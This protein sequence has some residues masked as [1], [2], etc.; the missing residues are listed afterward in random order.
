MKLPIVEKKLAYLFD[1]LVL[2]CWD[3]NGLDGGELQDA[4]VEA[5]VMKEVMATEPCGEKCDCREYD[6]FP[7]TC[8]RKNY[9]R[10]DG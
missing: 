8:Y 6:D 1:A 10:P 5:G 3:G 4:L 9:E 7:Q 2:A